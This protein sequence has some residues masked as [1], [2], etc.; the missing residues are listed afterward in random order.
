MNKHEQGLAARRRELV[1]R[2]TAQRA[3][4]LSSAEPLARKAA[5][6]DRIAA[7]V[8]RYPFVAALAVGAVCLVGPRKL[9][10]LGAR[11]VTLYLLLKRST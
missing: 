3:A 2:S 9:F 4:L 10:D 8:R 1:E 5:A 6:L 11:A 7:S